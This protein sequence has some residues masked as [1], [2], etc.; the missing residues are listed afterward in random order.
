MYRGSRRPGVV[1]GRSVVEPAGATGATVA[2]ILWDVEGVAWRL[3]LRRLRRA[4]T[5]TGAGRLPLRP[6]DAAGAGLLW[7][8]WRWP[9]ARSAL[10]E[11]R[12]KLAG[13]PILSGWFW[14]A[15]LWTDG[16]SLRGVAGRRAMLAGV[17]ARRL[18]AAIEA[19]DVRRRVRR[20]TRRLVGCLAGLLRLQYIRGERIAGVRA[21]GERRAG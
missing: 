13:L 12:A 5:A 17:A 7:S 15:C 1:G 10:I 2:A 20:D 19:R 16:A 6:L 9:L 3:L 4:V 11:E 14:L 18:L 21:G 8:T